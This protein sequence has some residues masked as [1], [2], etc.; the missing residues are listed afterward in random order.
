M[1]WTVAGVMWGVAGMVRG[2]VYG[3]CYCYGAWGVMQG[4]GCNEEHGRDAGRGVLFRCVECNAG[5]GW[6]LV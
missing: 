4:V 2:V 1:V 3:V 5:R 6:V